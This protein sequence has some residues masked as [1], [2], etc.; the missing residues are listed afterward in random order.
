MVADTLIIRYVSSKRN[1]ASVL[2]IA[3]NFNVNKVSIIVT[4]H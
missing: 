3:E 1:D 4:T 2:I